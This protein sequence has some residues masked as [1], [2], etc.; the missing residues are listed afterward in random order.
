M[1]L[2]VP[3][4]CPVVRGT[5]GQDAPVGWACLGGPDRVPPARVAG[6]LLSPREDALS[7]CRLP[8]LLALLGHSRHCQKDTDRLPVGKAAPPHPTEEM[9]F[10]SPAPCLRSRA[11]ISVAL[12]QPTSSHTPSPRLPQPPPAPDT[13]PGSALAADS[14]LPGSFLCFSSS[15]PAPSGAPGL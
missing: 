7:S 2:R 6:S 4:R 13:L 9:S 1:L 12:N 5:P 3:A 11:R 10:P 8:T 15:S 14:P